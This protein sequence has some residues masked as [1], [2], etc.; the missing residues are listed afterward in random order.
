[1]EL[2]D[3]V[4]IP[5]EVLRRPRGSGRTTAQIKALKTDDVLVVVYGAERSY[6]RGLILKHRP[7]IN[8]GTDMPVVPLDRVHDLLIGSQRRAVLDH[9]A[10]A[11]L[12]VHARSYPG[13]TEFLLGHNARLA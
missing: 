6:V 8:T 13:L 11:E 12:T 10:Y 1:M 4:N 5:D 9:H 2:R 3:L 7:D